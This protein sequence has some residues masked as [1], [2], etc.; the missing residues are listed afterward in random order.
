MFT[1]LI[2]SSSHAKEFKRRGSF[3]L[4]TTITYGVLLVA[5][6]V[7]SVYAYD[8][9]LEEQNLEMVVLINP[10]DFAPEVRPP[11]AAPTQRPR[12]TDNNN[13][14]ESNVAE[15]VDPMLSVNR[16]ERVP[17]EVS[18]RPNT[19]PPIPDSGH[20]RIGTQNREAGVPAGPGSDSGGGGQV[21]PSR[22]VVALEEPPPDLEKPETPRVVS[23]GVI[24]SQALSLPKPNYPPIAKQMGIQGMVS[25]QVLIDETGKVISAKAVGGSPFLTAEA[26]KAAFQAR[27][28]PT[29]L[30]DQAV[31]VSGV[32]TYNFVL[33][34]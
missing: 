25:V 8:A 13:N 16:P 32:I 23:K 18:A 26:Q 9:R 29:I 34:R 4:F 15:R 21:T 33:G 31:R 11:A 10:Q 2:E 14:N 22:Q 30:S 1:H 24:T 3:L 6:G 7:I 5:T 20:W 27:F 19:N 17:D 12:S 28:S